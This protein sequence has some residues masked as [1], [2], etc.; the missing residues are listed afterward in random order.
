M[1]EELENVYTF[2]V[3]KLILILDYEQTARLDETARLDYKQTA[4]LDETAM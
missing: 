2:F 3:F 1:N 4:R